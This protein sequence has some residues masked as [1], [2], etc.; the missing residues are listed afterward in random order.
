MTSYFP[1]LT[2]L[3]VLPIFA[4]SSI[5]FS[6]PRGNMVYSGILSVYVS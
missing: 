4:G 6:P 1:W 2:I 3:L 5:I